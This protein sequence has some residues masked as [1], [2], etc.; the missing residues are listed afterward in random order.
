MPKTEKTGIIEIK[1]PRARLF[2]R[3]DFHIRWQG[4]FLRNKRTGILRKWRS[5]DFAETL[6]WDV[7]PSIRVMTLRVFSKRNRRGRDW[8]LRFADD[9]QFHTLVY[10][11]LTSVVSHSHCG[12]EDG[13]LSATGIE[14][15]RQ[16]KLK[17]KRGFRDYRRTHDG[18]IEAERKFAAGTGESL[19]HARDRSTGRISGESGFVYKTSRSLKGGGRP[20]PFSASRSV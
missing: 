1:A 13:K 2:V 5:I 10:W 3:H 6:G 14:A 17:G 9:D 16:G 11:F 20:R 8:F 12:L 15:K 19:P 7:D 18:V 4:Q